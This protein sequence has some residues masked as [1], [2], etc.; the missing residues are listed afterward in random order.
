VSQS[1]PIVVQS[2]LDTNENILL[3]Q[4]PEVHLHPRAQAA[5][6]SFFSHLVSDSDAQIIIETHSD[7]LLDRI[8]RSVA[9][10]EITPNKVAILYFDKEGVLVQREL[11]SLPVSD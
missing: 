5:L 2:L 3:L 4:Q 8:R 6:G 7:Y 9:R 11:E 1:L 10:R